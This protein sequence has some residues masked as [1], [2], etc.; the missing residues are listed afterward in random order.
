MLT[1]NPPQDNTRVQH[2]NNQQAQAKHLVLQAN[3]H[4]MNDNIRVQHANNQPEHDKMTQQV[5]NKP[6][7]DNTGVQHVNNQPVQDT[8]MHHANN[9]QAKTTTTWY[10]KPT[11]NQWIIRLWYNMTTGNR[12][13]TTTPYDTK[14]IPLQMVCRM[15]TKQPVPKTKQ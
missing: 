8:M 4:P 1:I 10:Y 9:Q 12:L 6:L 5:N 3:N 11:S 7:Q 14:K 13:K 2:A 15:M